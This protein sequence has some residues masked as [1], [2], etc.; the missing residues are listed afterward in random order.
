MWLSLAKA[1]ELTSGSKGNQQTLGG[2]K[3]FN[4][5]RGVKIEVLGAFLEARQQHGVV[6]HL[7]QKLSNEVSSLT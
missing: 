6:R 7:H 4:A 1:S 5:Y 3:D 2:T